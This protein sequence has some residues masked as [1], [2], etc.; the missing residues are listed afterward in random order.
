MF[1]YKSIAT[2][3]F[4]KVQYLG[5]LM[6]LFSQQDKKLTFSFFIW[7]FD[8]LIKQ[9]KQRRIILLHTKKLK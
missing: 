2:A 8:P 1:F 7:R 5:I 9:E 4:S 6:S 3:N